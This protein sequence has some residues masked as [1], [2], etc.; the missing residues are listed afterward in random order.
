MSWTTSSPGLRVSGEVYL[1]HGDSGQVGPHFTSPWGCRQQYWS[2]Q[3]WGPI[4]N[5]ARALLEARPSSAATWQPPLITYLLAALQHVPC[6][7]SI[8]SGGM[9]G[10]ASRH[11][12]SRDGLISTT[13]ATSAMLCLDLDRNITASPKQAVRC[14]MGHAGPHSDWSAPS[15]LPL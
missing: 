7:A 3:Q 1:A 9:S 6:S 13:T 4:P 10:I 11:Y 14:E 15:F 5:A 8:A 12:E 2:Q